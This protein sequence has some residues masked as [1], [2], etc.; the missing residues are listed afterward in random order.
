M[1]EVRADDREARSGEFHPM[2]RHQRLELAVAHRHGRAA[3][4]GHPR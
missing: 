3:Q 2:T 4:L 1:N